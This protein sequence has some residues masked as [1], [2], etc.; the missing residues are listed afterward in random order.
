MK[1]LKLIL[2]AILLIV[3]TSTFAI[4][5]KTY[6]S[7]GAINLWSLP[8]DGGWYKNNTYFSVSFAHL[9]NY[10]NVYCIQ[11]HQSFPRKGIYMEV[12]YKIVINGE[13]AKIYQSDKLYPD[14]GPLV[15]ECNGDYNNLLAAIVCEEAMGLG[16]GSS[17]SGY[18]NSQVD[19]YYYWNDWLVES[20]ANK[21]MLGSSGNKTIVDSLGQQ[22]INEIM[23]EYKDYAS[24]Y[25]YNATIY[26]MTPVFNS[27]Q[28]LL[29]VER[30][31]KTELDIDIP[32]TKIWNDGENV[33]AR[34]EIK[35]E[36]LANGKSTG[37]TLTLNKDNNWKSEFS[38]LEIKDSSGNRIDYTIKEIDSPSGYVS[39][40]IGNMSEGYK[41]TNTQLTQVNVEKEWNDSED[42]DEYR[43]TTLKVTLYADGLSTGKTVALDA[44][45]EWKA[46]FEKLNKYDKNGKLIDYTVQEEIVEKYEEPEYSKSETSEG[47]IKWIIKNSYTPE[48]DGYIEI[49]GKVWSDNPDG[50]GNDINGIFDEKDSLLEGITVRLKYIDENGNH[51]IF[52]SE[53]PTAYETK[54]NSKGE[55]TIAVNYDNRENVYKLHEDSDTVNKKLQTAY[56]EFE[57]DGVKYTTVNNEISTKKVVNEDGSESI[58]ETSSQEQSKA[59]E[60]ETQR[61]DLDNKH[62]TVTTQTAHP[63]NWEDKNITAVT[64]TVTSYEKGQDENKEVVLKYCNGNGTCD[65]TNPE[66]AWMVIKGEQHKYPCENCPESGHDM[67]KYNVTVQKIPN[68]NLGLFKREQPDVAIFSDLTKVEVEMKGQKYTYLYGV[69][70]A[71]AN[72]VG[73]QVKFQDKDTYTYKRPVNPA[74]IAYI[75]EEANKNAMNVVVTYEVKVGN[76]ST[77][78]PITVHSITNSFDS[79]YTLNTTEWTITDAEGFKQATYNGDLN[80]TVEPQKESTAI[81]LKY[82]VSIEAIR[83]LLDEEA[84]LNNAVEIASYSTRYG[85][86]TLYAEQR[87]G[88]RTGNA[89]AGYD[90]NSHPGNAGIFIN[91]DGRLEA[92][93]PEDDTDIAPSF[94]LCKDDEPKTLSGSIWEDKDANIE[95]E[96]R[97]G[98]G[99]FDSGEQ[100]VENVKVE[101]YEIRRDADGNVVSTDLAKLYNDETKQLDR[102]AIVYSEPDG[103]YKLDGVVTG[104]YFVKY[105]YGNDVTKLGHEATT[106]DGGKT[107]VNARNYKSTIITEKL[108]KQLLNKDYDKFSEDEKKWHITHEKGYSVAVDNM[109][110]RLNVEDLQYSNF[111]NP[112]NITAYTKPFKT[113]VEFETTGSSNSD[114]EGNLEGITNVL[115]KLDFGIVERPREDLYAEKTI[116]YFKITLA[117]GQVLTEGNPSQPGVDINYAKPIGFTQTINNGEEARRALEKTL[118]VEIDTEL[119]QGAQLDVKYAVNVTNNNELDYDYGTYEDYKSDFENS[120]KREY[121]KFITQVS[122]ARYYYYGEKNGLNPMKT[123]VQFVDYM[124]NDIIYSDN[125]QWKT[126]KI[127]DIYAEGNK[128]INDNT[129]NILK[130]NMYKILQSA[131]GETVTLARGETSNPLEVLAS[132]VLSN[133]D[134]NV[135]DNNV[136]ILK[137]DG[138]TARTI[139]QSS[140]GEQIEK[141]YKPGNYIPGVT[142]QEESEP[143]D[144]R[145]KIIITPPTGIT[146]YIITYVIAGLVGL[147]G[148]VI[149]VLF[150]KKKVLK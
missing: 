97:L 38:D 130:D 85:Q 50:K 39:A 1:R 70:G 26:Y 32:V 57:Y 139:Q 98:N 28:R 18:N 107:T 115:D 29:L 131:A 24:K 137:I 47:Y 125:G 147:I 90:Y 81:E 51:Q 110:E 73:L 76:L 43:P 146:N 61:N 117:N 121:D 111:N 86:D 150:I 79:E 96:E 42:L 114:A 3:L 101:L 9:L 6:S 112:L 15:M 78:L 123:T 106:M 102:D 141:T 8:E 149:G 12:Q 64:K 134:D 34:T 100:N 16:Y 55:Y 35:V 41:I 69:R 118:L 44:G 33:D 68:I 2:I 49:S 83:K 46:T 108:V 148:I 119:I 7:S 113:Q 104:E 54:T 135:Y 63:N 58:V 84:T 31:D 105:T 67:K 72:D 53:I 142:L 48:Y 99:R 10:N 62:Q 25:L 21:Y 138:K 17:S 56:V 30:G 126:L 14:Y 127:E 66:S 93:K 74:D 109:Q 120:L 122:K 116:T 20:G 128:L 45:N 22:R 75:Q 80:I 95:D 60:N 145:V 88:G 87:A 13:N 129:Y 52:N 132:K 71:D 19:L 82:T 77:T 133:K 59:V 11:R 143:D 91:N 23:K 4:V 140:E 103:I 136:E 37:K 65:R 36:L 124:D 27:V 5:N 92:G 144:D 94:V 89:Y 40:T